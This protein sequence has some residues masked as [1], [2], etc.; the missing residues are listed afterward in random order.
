MAAQNS[1]EEIEICEKDFSRL[2]K[3][4]KRYTQIPLQ[5]KPSMARDMDMK[6]KW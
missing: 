5:A 4:G 1:E 3:D 2:K 6:T